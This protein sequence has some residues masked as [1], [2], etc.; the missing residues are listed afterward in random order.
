M[1]TRKEAVIQMIENRNKITNKLLGNIIEYIEDEMQR[2]I[3]Q[4][5]GEVYIDI[6][7][8]NLNEDSYDLL[9]TYLEAKGFHIKTFR[10]P[11]YENIAGITIQWDLPLWRRLF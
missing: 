2:A 11:I 1:L 5:E 3:N 7:K 8:F 10:Y 4:G 9:V 6:D